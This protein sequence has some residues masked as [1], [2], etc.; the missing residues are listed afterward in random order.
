MLGYFFNDSKK[1]FIKLQ[2]ILDTNGKI[3]A[4]NLCLAT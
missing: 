3:A 4:E 1:F 2:L